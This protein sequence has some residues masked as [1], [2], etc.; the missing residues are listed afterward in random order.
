MINSIYSDSPNKK[1]NIHQDLDVFAHSHIPHTFSDQKL[2]NLSCISKCGSDGGNQDVRD[3]FESES[4]FQN[5]VRKF[6][7]MYDNI[8]VSKSESQMA[9]VHPAGSI[10]PTE[11]GLT[12]T[13]TNAYAYTPQDGQTHAQYTSPRVLFT[14]SETEPSRRH[15]EAGVASAANN[16]RRNQTQSESQTA[17]S[18]IDL[19][20]GIP[21]GENHGR[22]DWTESE[23]QAV[24]SRT[25]LQ[26]NTSKSDSTSDFSSVPQAQYQDGRHVTLHNAHRDISQFLHDDKQNVGKARAAQGV[27][28]ALPSHESFK[29]EPEQTTGENVWRCLFMFHMRHLHTF[30]MRM[31]GDVSSCFMLGMYVCVYINICIHIRRYVCIYMYVCMHACIYARTNTH[32]H[33][34]AHTHT[35]THRHTHTHT[36]THTQAHTHTHTHTHRHRHRPTNPPQAHCMG[37]SLQEKFQGYKL[38]F[39]QH[40]CT[41]SNFTADIYRRKPP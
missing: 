8:A 32:T 30:F 38:R 22:R 25:Y 7:G 12:Y 2:S 40:Q 20:S 24:V 41:S 29:N 39:R 14:N 31:C 37:S 10:S 1:R 26:S 11:S 21:K 15:R 17:T 9:S 18:R 23:L 16:D 34:H 27:S 36:H 13:R 33:T 19:H 3:Q 28:Q 5:S 6:P 4:G 35:H